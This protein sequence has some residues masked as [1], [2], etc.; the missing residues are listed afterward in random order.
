MLPFFRWAVSARSPLLCKREGA[1]RWDD[2]PVSLQSR[3][4][5]EALTLR[6]AIQGLKTS[7]CSLPLAELGA[8]LSGQE[9]EDDG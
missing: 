4:A 1:F 2:L 5:A 8:C 6:P 7:S 9:P 3:L